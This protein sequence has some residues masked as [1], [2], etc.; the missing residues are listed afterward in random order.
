VK[1]GQLEQKV[2]NYSPKINLLLSSNLSVHTHIILQKIGLFALTVFTTIIII[3]PE[4][5]QKRCRTNLIFWIFH[6]SADSFLAVS[7][8]LQ[9]KCVHLWRNYVI[10]YWCLL[11][12]INSYLKHFAFKILIKFSKKNFCINENSR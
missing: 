12:K 6:C 8:S 5:Y 11:K 4:I 2:H 7:Q 1:L 10:I 9:P 3:I